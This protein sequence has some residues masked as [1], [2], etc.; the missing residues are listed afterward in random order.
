M[1]D[2]RIEQVLQTGVVTTGNDVCSIAVTDVP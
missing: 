1:L 2:E